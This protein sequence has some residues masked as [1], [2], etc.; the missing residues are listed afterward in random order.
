MVEERVTD[1][2]I[3]RK[4]NGSYMVTIPLEI[5]QVLRLTVGQIVDVYIDKPKRK[6]CY[7]TR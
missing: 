2:K 7:M 3:Q 4:S 6:I 1:V 5:A